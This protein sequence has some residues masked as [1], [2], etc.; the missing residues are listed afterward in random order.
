MIKKTRVMGILN[1][2]PDSFSDGGFFF[3]PENAIRRASELVRDGADIIDIGA[4]STRPG[5]TPIDAAEEISRLEK[6]IPAIKNFGVPVSID[7]YKPEV[8]EIALKLGADMINDVSGLKNLQMPDVAKKYDCPLVVMHNEKN[9]CENIIDD[10]KIFFRKTFETC[11]I[12]GFDCSKIIFD[13]GIGFGKTQEENLIVLKN[14]RELK[15]SCGENLL[16]LGASRK[17]FIGHFAGFEVDD[18]DEATGAVCVAGILSGADIVRVHNVK[19]IS[20]MCRMTDIL[21]NF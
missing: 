15:N 10:V 11:R 1:V 21:K 5:F 16:L 20:K 8:A 14:L 2:T 13:P 9:F 18:R 17:S 3:T 7:T 4:E 12:S 19:M 6:I